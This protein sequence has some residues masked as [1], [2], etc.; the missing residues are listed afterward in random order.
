MNQAA[1]DL[2]VI[3]RRTFRGVVQNGS[4]LQEGGGARELHTK[5]KKGLS[6]DQDIPWGKGMDE[7]F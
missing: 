6:L 3:N 5:E 2:A 1:S 7:G 4:L